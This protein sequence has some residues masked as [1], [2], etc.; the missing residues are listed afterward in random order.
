[1]NQRYFKKKIDKFVSF[2]ERN[3]GNPKHQYYKQKN[4][5]DKLKSFDIFN[6]LFYII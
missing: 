3:N 4:Q 2:L 6:K 1:M 5:K